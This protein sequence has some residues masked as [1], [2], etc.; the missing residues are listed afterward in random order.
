MCAPRSRTRSSSCSGKSPTLGTLLVRSRRSESKCSGPEQIPEGSSMTRPGA[1]KITLPL[2]PIGLHVSTISQIVLTLVI[3]TNR[4]LLE[5]GKPVGHQ[6]Q[7]GS[8][9]ER[10]R[11]AGKDMSESGHR[12]SH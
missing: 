12:I 1:A 9:R 8:K 3:S 6:E 5:N 4:T 2:L 7:T 10:G 11:A